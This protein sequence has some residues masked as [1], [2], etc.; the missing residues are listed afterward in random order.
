MVPGIQLRPLCMLGKNGLDT[1]GTLK[2]QHLVTTP[3]HMNEIPS[4]CS[5]TFLP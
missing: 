2:C 1:Q 5:L 3:S 4:L